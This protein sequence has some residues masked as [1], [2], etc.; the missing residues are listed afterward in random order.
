MIVFTKVLTTSRPPARLGLVLWLCSATI[1]ANAIQGDWVEDKTKLCGGFYQPPVV[2]ELSDQDDHAPLQISA[3]QS[4]VHLDG[5]TLLLGDVAI[6]Q[7]LRRIHAN[8][9]RIEHEP[10][11]RTI[12]SID[13]YGSIRFVQPGLQVF[14]AHA[15]A[16]KDTGEMKVDEAQYRFYE[17]HARGAAK[18][19]LVDEDKTSTLIDATYTTC[20]P[21]NNTWEL[22]AQTVELDQAKGRGSAWHSWISFWDQPVVYL[23]YFNFPI[24]DARK[25]GLLFPSFGQSDD[26]G[27]NFSIP[28]YLNL[29]PNYDAQLNF[30][31]IEKKGVGLDTTLRYLTKSSHGELQLDTIFHDASYVDFRREK[32]RSHPTIT[33]TN[34]PRLNGLHGLHRAYLQYQHHTDFTKRLGIDIDFNK[35]SD[36]NY[37]ADLEQFYMGN[38][39]NDIEQSY[40]LYYNGRGWNSNIHIQEFQ[41]LHPF[42]ASERE[43]IYRRQ[44]QFELGLDPKTMPLGLSFSGKSEIT[45][46]SIR[47]DRLSQQSKT[48]GDRWHVRP[49]LSLPVENVAGYIVPRVQ[50][51]FTHYNLENGTVALAQNKPTRPTRF[52]PM[53]DVKA[54]LWFEKSQTWGGHPFLQ[55]LEPQLYY[56]YVPYRDQDAYPN[57]DTGPTSFAIDRLWRDNRFSNHDRVGDANQISLGLSSR[58]MDMSHYFERLRASI[59]QIYY[60]ENRKVTSCDQQVYP[61]CRRLEDSTADDR[62]SPVIGLLGFYLTPELYTQSVYE[63]NH[64]VGETERTSVSVEYR[65]PN[66]A[67]FNLGTQYLRV[68]PSQTDL[69]TGNQF[70]LNQVSLSAF[71]PISQRWRALGRTFYDRAEHHLIDMMAGVEYESCCIAVQFL[72][73]RTLNANGRDILAQPRTHAGL[74]PYATTFSIQVTLKGLST[75]GLHDND[76]KMKT[77]IPGYRPFEARMKRP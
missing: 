35:V 5:H 16:D 38:Q 15:S 6:E 71:A 23:P 55:T 30:K 66:D 4:K 58:L 59:G 32:R 14:G 75:L 62:L 67:V 70:S 37:F 7:G 39:I 46:F 51:D 36:D 24:N 2:G 48:H 53:Y 27:F 40:R 42:N 44:P 50:F 13:A 3:D 31:Y 60:F 41:V 1:Q 19:V 8:E 47:K 52:I 68:D 21:G 43:E 22:S 17:R 64:Q 77:L 25:S 65:G 33:N 57:F 73:Q 11:T 76:K 54:G 12:K 9:A 28:I 56:L 20:P 10:G 45:R 69:D 61:N 26:F 63:F 18:S 29:A 49:E 34:D 74:D 72:A